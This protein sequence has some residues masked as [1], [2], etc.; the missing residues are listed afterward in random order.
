ME[1]IRTACVKL[2]SILREILTQHVCVC[3]EH[4]IADTYSTNS[5]LTSVMHREGTF[6]LVHQRKWTNE[7]PSWVCR[8]EHSHIAYGSQKSLFSQDKPAI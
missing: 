2:H 8:L 4:L 6:A 1:F 3:V 7:P 5:A